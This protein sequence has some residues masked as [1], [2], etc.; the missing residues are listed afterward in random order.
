MPIIFFKEKESESNFY[1]D[2]CARGSCRI[3]VI[4][5]VL[6]LLLIFCLYWH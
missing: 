1:T 5:F 6:M 3:F 4:T 2:L